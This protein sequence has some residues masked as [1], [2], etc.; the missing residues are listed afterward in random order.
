MES[1]PEINPSRTA[2]LGKEEFLDIILRSK[3]PPKKALELSRKDYTFGLNRDDFEAALTKVAIPSTHRDSMLDITLHF[4][5]SL[6]KK[7]LNCEKYN[8]DSTKLFE[9]GIADLQEEIVKTAGAYDYRDPLAIKQAKSRLYRMRF[10][11][12]YVASA[13]KISTSELPILNIYIKISDL[14]GQEASVNEMIKKM[15]EIYPERNTR[16]L[17]EFSQ[18]LSKIHS[19]YRQYAEKSPLALR[20]DNQTRPTE[21]IQEIDELKKEIRKVLM[22]LNKNQRGVIVGK[23]FEDKT[24]EDMGKSNNITRER[25]RQLQQK[26]LKKL[27]EPKNSQKLKLYLKPDYKPPIK[28]PSNFKEVHETPKEEHINESAG[29]YRKKYVTKEDE[30]LLA[31]KEWANTDTRE[32]LNMTAQNKNTLFVSDKYPDIIEADNVWLKTINQM[33]KTHIPNSERRVLVGVDSDKR[34]ILSKVLPYH[35][36]STNF[37]HETD[38]RRAQ[39]NEFSRNVVGEIV[40]E[41]Y[42]PAIFLLNDKPFFP[43]EVIYQFLTDPDKLNFKYIDT[44][45]ETYLLFRAKNTLKREVVPN[46][47]DFEYVRDWCYSKLDMTVGRVFNKVLSVDGLSSFDSKADRKRAGILLCNTYNLVLYQKLKDDSFIRLTH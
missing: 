45:D 13:F 47:N 12:E 28:L 17:S 30:P 46:K 7:S 36:K 41:P 6:A 40:I 15:N 4:L 11:D 9:R 18:T 8:I 37:V 25:V 26:A 32:Y 23:Y 3:N 20:A 43:M 10:I 34:L 39:A 19:R 27:R 29:K 22:E 2:E 31:K 16:D 1:V 14:I 44:I 42:W 21:K 33:H 5:P 38:L 35:S 24:L